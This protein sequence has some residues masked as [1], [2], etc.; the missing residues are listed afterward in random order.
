MKLQ[1]FRKVSLTVVFLMLLTT[2]CY[3]K[4]L[5]KTMSLGRGTPRITQAPRTVVLHAGSNITQYFLIP[6]QDDCD[7]IWKKFLVAT[8]YRWL[9]QNGG[10]HIDGEFNMIENCH[11]TDVPFPGRTAA[12]LE[13]I[14]EAIDD[15]GGIL[16][17]SYLRTVQG[18]PFYHSSIKFEEPLK[19]I[20][21]FTLEYANGPETLS[22]DYQIFFDIKDAVA[23]L[24][25]FM[26]V[27]NLPANK[28]PFTRFF[29][30][31]YSKDAINIFLSAAGPKAGSLT[32]GYST[33][34]L[35]RNART[36]NAWY[37]GNEVDYT[38]SSLGKC[39]R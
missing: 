15:E 37:W 13:A 38:C 35:L 19:T 11:R 17:D 20:Y 28:E 4:P 34:Y 27:M 16:L 10:D 29:E 39:F 36:M 8:N 7:T 12:F 32:Y 6:T 1:G 14:V 25:D 24:A 5:V 9:V 33:I 23:T 18:N 2:L 26:A 31:T 30:K 3:A 21:N 22:D